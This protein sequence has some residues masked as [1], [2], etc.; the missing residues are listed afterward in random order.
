MN[1]SRWVLIPLMLPASLGA[2][3]ASEEERAAEACRAEVQRRLV[4]P[5]SATFRNVHAKRVGGE[6]GDWRVDLIVGAANLAG[7]SSSA[8]VSCMLGPKLELLDLEGE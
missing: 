4:I 7:E 2:G 3:C 5:S 8:S 6:A 1:H